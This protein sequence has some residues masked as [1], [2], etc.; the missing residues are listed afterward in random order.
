MLYFPDTDEIVTIGAKYHN[1][2]SS[3][4]FL[5][6]ERPAMPRCVHYFIQ[7]LRWIMYNDYGHAM[8]GYSLLL[9]LNDTN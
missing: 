4:S 2:L 6:K 8:K 7:E 5:V 1:G 3:I 9:S